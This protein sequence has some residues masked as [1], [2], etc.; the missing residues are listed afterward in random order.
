MAK[1]PR[2]SVGSLESLPSDE[3]E[4]DPTYRATLDW[5]WSFSA[6][7]RTPAEMAAQRAVKLERMTAL[8]A[9]LGHPE[10]E[11]PSV[12]VAG[13]KGKGSTVAML[14]ACLGTAGFRTGRYTSPHLVNWRERTCINA[15]P[16]STTDV[17]ELAKPIRRAVERVPTSFGP[18]T[19]FEVGTA[20]A[21]LYFARREVDVAVVE[22]G[23][24]G[25]FDATNLVDPTVS[26]ITPVSYDHTQT[27]GDTLSS[28]AW[29]KAGILRRDRPA[30][31][32]PQVE[33]ARMAIEHE[34]QLLNASLE[35]V[36]REW[37]WSASGAV[38]HISSVHDDFATLDVEVNLVGD[39][40]RDNATTAAAALYAVRDRFGVSPEAMR[41]ALRTV[42]WPGRLQVLAREPLVVLDGA[43]NAASAEVVRRALEADLEFEQLHL[44]VG[45]T[46]GK[47]ALG[48]LTALAP[49]AD[50]VYL[51]R[52][53]HERSAPPAELE[54]LVRRTTQAPIRTFA[55]APAAFDAALAHAHAR[56]L[57]LV[58]GSLFLVG[59]ALEWWRRSPR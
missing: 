26:V 51:T 27:L 15:S 42:D 41:K 43:H 18:L 34:A 37:H 14:S 13:T 21:F 56:D 16:I 19:T 58:T 40:Q 31:S 5:I 24:G 22:V 8:L 12:L 50:A 39:H 17:L 7:T 57:V 54:P 44:V 3:S 36:G 30:V 52:S 53:R 1:Q 23:T 46:E 9:A 20:F 49:R 59:E 32:A 10:R 33:E 2:A 29:H 38:T 6:R 11:F 55:D 28:I 4:P 48:V 35:E 47:D 25:R 45:L